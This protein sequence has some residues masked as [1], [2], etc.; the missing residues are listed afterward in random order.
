MITY[1]NDNGQSVTKSPYVYDAG[2]EPSWYEYPEDDSGFDKYM[3][4]LLQSKNILDA[5]PI[6]IPGGSSSTFPNR[7]SLNTN[8]F[9]DAFAKFMASSDQPDR[10]STRGWLMK[11]PSPEYSIFNFS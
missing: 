3:R 11:A 7:G 8:S 5:P 1:L 6:L 2:T 4:E 10:W 9:D